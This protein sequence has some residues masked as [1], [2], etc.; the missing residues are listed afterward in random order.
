M[1]G[2]WVKVIGD[3]PDREG[4]IQPN[5]SVEALAEAVRRVHAAGARL[6]VHTMSV[7][8]VELAVEAGV[9]SIEHGEGM[10]DDH[11]AAMARDGITL[12]P[13]MTILPVLPEM[14]GQMGLSP[15]QLTT[16]QDDIARH[17]EMV[18]RAADAGVQILAGTDAG[19]V[20]HGLVREEIGRL[21]D[22][23]HRTG[24]TTRRDIRPGR[25]L[26]TGR[27]ARARLEAGRR[28]APPRCGGEDRA[29]GGRSRPDCGP[30]SPT[31]RAGRR[32][33][34]S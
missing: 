20:A 6:A 11:L 17:P 31:R 22:A 19:L 30:F 18:A 3:F 16:T 13:T 7:A 34:G 27:E 25:S 29:C 14:V 4:A 26:R 10:R 28:T 2:V 23:E 33:P 8:G 21:A 1:S 32:S 15:P 9:D 5:Y 12:V 24:G